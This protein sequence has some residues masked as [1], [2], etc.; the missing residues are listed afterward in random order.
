MTIDPLRRRALINGG[1]AAAVTLVV[2]YG[3]VASVEG[4]ELEDALPSASPSTTTSPAPPPCQPS[5]EVVQSADPGDLPN[6]LHGIAAISSA[7]AWAVGASG[8]PSAPTAVLIERWDGTAWT[9]EQGPSPGSE[10]NEL[11]DVD[12]SEPNDVWAVGR[13]A[14][15]F[16]DRPLALH[17]DG[18]TWLEVDLP[19]ELTGV[20]TGVAA[21]APDDVWVVGYTGDPDAQLERAL[22]LHWDGLLWAAVDAGRSV[23][24]VG[25]SALLDVEATGGELPTEVWAVGYLHAGPLIVRFDGQDW[26][27]S[28]TGIAGEANAIEPLSPG[29]GWVVGA[30]I[31]RFNG[32]TWT[33]AA[34][35]RAGGE[36][37]GVAA[38]G[39]ADVW[40]VGLRPT[41]DGSTKSLVVR[42]DGTA[43]KPVDGPGVP[44]S[45][46]LTDVAAL[47]DGTVLAVGYQ[48]VDLGR[49][50]LSVLGTTCPPEG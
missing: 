11:L 26:T 19:D 38:I 17:Y 16:G 8:D 21:V 35:V 20:L 32:D 27:R 34:N 42:W 49:R 45:D 6:G 10:A 39:G 4:G 47:P 46:A 43:W 31:Q 22:I 1:L 9:A 37:F 41:E 25:R 40:A 7:E 23:V 33:P 5:W 30:P 12:A 15:G 36:L 50:T 3:I 18:T 14:S 44:G 2:G 28:Q 24:G 13:T 29:D 48:D